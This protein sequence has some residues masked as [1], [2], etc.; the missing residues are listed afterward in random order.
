MFV[1]C[2]VCV[3]NVEWVCLCVWVFF[4]LHHLLGPCSLL[5][6][7]NVAFALS[8]R[9]DPNDGCNVLSPWSAARGCDVA[10]M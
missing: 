1:V 2:V 4:Y 9:A 7:M 5:T 10:D 3:V 8:I 6:L